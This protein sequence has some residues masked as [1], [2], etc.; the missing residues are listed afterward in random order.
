[1]S[2]YF[3]SGQGQTHTQTQ[4]QTH[5]LGTYPEDD[6]V[7]EEEIFIP[8]AD[9]SRRIPVVV[10]LLEGSNCAEPGRENC[11][12][13]REKLLDSANVAIQIRWCG[14]LVVKTLTSHSEG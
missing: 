6:V 8:T 2:L 11:W 3:L 13:A 5:R 4:T 9:F 14:G 7:A 1:M 12:L 10:H